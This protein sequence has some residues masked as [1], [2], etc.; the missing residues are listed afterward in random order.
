MMGQVIT[1]Q[2]E[3]GGMTRV[4]E[5]GYIRAGTRIILPDGTD[6]ALLQIIAASGGMLCGNGT[7]TE[8]LGGPEMPFLWRFTE[9]LP[10]PEDYVLQRSGITLDDIYTA[11]E[12]EGSGPRLPLAMAAPN[13]QDAVASKAVRAKG[14]HGAQPSAREP[15][16]AAIGNRKQ[17]RANASAARRTPILH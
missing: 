7:I 14:M 10:K 3:P 5:S 8:T 15:T 9:S 1:G 16:L 12:W 17:R 11:N 2:R 6:I 4:R 13:N